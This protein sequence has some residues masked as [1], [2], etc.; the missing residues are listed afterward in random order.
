METRQD[1]INWAE[2]LGCTVS[3]SANLGADAVLVGV[4]VVESE[5]G[6]V[7]IEDNSLAR[8]ID[9]Q[10]LDWFCRRL[11]LSPPS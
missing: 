11:G 1:C 7:H 8:P 3:G 5:E 9:P 6:F 2:E 10:W 4:T